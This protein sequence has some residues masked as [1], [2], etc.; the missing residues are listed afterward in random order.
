MPNFKKVKVFGRHRSFER[1]VPLNV[2][3]TDEQ[4]DLEA[5]T[6]LNETQRSAVQGQDVQDVSKHRQGDNPYLDEYRA[7][8]ANP[9]PQYEP[10]LSPAM[11][12]AC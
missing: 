9:Q 5:G 7:C 12:F 11:S 4:A 6:F 1:P 8:V 10:I 3:D 2:Q